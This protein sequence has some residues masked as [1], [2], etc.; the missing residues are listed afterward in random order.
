[1]QRVR[2]EPTTKTPKSRITSAHAESTCA[3]RRSFRFLRDHLCACREYSGSPLYCPPCGGS[4]LRMQ[5]V[6]YLLFLDTSQNGITSAH[7]ESTMKLAMKFD[8]FKDHLCACREYVFKIIVIAYLTGSPLR[9]QRVL[10]QI[11]TQSK[12]FRITSAHAE[13]TVNP[14]SL[15]SCCEDHLCACREYPAKRQAMQ[16]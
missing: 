16:R 7:A 3:K 5:R 10:S 9:M 4:P 12:C 13:S 15:I 1:M 2:N 8:E 14:L 6:P 11:T